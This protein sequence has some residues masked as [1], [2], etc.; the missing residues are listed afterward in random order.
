MENFGDR[1]P[2]VFLPVFL[3]LESLKYLKA[4]FALKV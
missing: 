3:L 4:L 2:D 1:S